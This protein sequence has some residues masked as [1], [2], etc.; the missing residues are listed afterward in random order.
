MAFLYVKTQYLV[1]QT[2]VWNPCFVLHGYIIKI[3]VGEEKHPESIFLSL[4]SEAE[5]DSVFNQGCDRPQ[6]QF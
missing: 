1:Q 5:L 3:K 4:E 6:G 2:I